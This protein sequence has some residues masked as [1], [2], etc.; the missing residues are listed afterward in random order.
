ME[1]HYKIQRF[2]EYNPNFGKKKICM[3][4]GAEGR[5]RGSVV[6][7]TDH[8]SY[9][10]FSKIGASCALDFMADHLTNETGYSREFERAYHAEFHSSYDS[11]EDDSSHSVSEE[12]EII[13]DTNSESDETI[14]EGSSVWTE[15]ITTNGLNYVTIND[16]TINEVTINEVSSDNESDNDVGF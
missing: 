5:K 3:V 12:E 11:S 9:D 10:S 16:V 8:L 15:F 6:F 7:N 2:I 13:E 4:P 14:V 1:F